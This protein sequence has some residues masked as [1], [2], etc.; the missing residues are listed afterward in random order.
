[1]P[2]SYLEY[3]HPRT[4]LARW[5]WGP[6]IVLRVALVATYLVSVYASVWAFIAGIPIFT[7]TSPEGYTP[8]W[9]VLLGTAGVVAA[10]GSITDRWSKIE[11]WAALTLFSLWLAYFGG[12]N[13]VGFTLSD[14]DRQFLGG[15]SIQH[16]IIPL[17]RF[18]Y[19]AAQSGKKKYVTPGVGS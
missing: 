1:M 18:V 13:Y 12:M 15:A 11:K 10:V 5:A 7:L 4:R 17:V 19:L 9:A 3:I 14:T 8:V 16:L 6:T 2:L